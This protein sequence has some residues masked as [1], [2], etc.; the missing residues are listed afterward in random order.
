MPIIKHISVHKHPLKMFEYV[1]N[2][3]KTSEMKFVSGINCTPI[4]NLANNEFQKVFENFS[5]ERFYKN[6]LNGADEETTRKQKV[7]L[8]HYIQSFAP[9]EA[10]PEEAHRIGVEWARKVFGDKHQVLVSTH[11]DKGHLH[12]H[13][14]VAAYNL[15]GKAWYD[16]KKM[17]KY[18]RDISDRI[19]REHGLSVIRKN[20]YRANHKYGEWLARKNGTSWKAKLCDDIDRIILQDNVKSIDD[21][22]KEL[23][24]NGYEVTKHKYISVKPD[25]LKNRKPVRTLRLGDGYGFEE[26]QYRIENKNQEM[27]L[28]EAMKYE[29]VQREYA[30]CLR[31]LQITVYRNIENPVQAGYGDLRKSAELLTF[32]CDNEI[33]SAE[34]FE[35]LVNETADKVSELRRKKKNIEDE[36]T[37]IKQICKTAGKYLALNSKAMPNPQEI[38]ELRDLKKLLPTNISSI[39]YIETYKYKLETLINLLEE[40]E[41]QLAES[42]IHKRDYGRYYSFFLQQA[43][44]DY[45]FIR[46]QVK[47]EQKEMEKAAEFAKL[48]KNQ[49]DISHKNNYYL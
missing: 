8:H 48:E 36:I 5:G 15:E 14:A 25:Y 21:L 49:E 12:N 35:K 29:G 7:R 3:D 6:S 22:I 30:L 46:E 13:F 31:Q 10:T 40:T 33:Q 24:N 39:D 47:R 9:G 4:A 38:K 43:Q 34:D 19:A 32:L 17:L 11:I 28:S 23:Q 20:K 27:P 18:C 16:N 37:Q 44:S 26:L 41:E 1:L 42:E 2:G 45:D